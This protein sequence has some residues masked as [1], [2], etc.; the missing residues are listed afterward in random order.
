[1]MT[2]DDTTKEVGKT[3]LIAALSALAVGLVNWAVEEMKIRTKKKSE[4]KDP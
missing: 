1:M 4:A 3:V 2:S